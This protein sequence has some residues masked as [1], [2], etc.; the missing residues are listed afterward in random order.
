M[1][2]ATAAQGVYASLD[3]LVRLRHRSRGFSLLPKQPVQSLLAGRHASRLR[4]R[5]L[6]FEEIRKYLP[7][8]DIRQ[9]DWKVTARTRKPHA[10]VYTEER[11]R[12]VILLVDQRLGMFFGSKRNLKSV[13]ACELAAL[14]AW[15]TIDVQDRVG[16][17]VFNDRQVVSIRPHRSQTTVMRILHQVLDMNHA[18]HADST[19]PANPAMLND[20]LHRAQHLAPHDCLIVMITDGDGSDDKTQSLVSQIARHNDI[21]LAFVFDPMEAELPELSQVVLS[22]GERQLEL[23]ASAELQTRYRDDFAEKRKQ[24]KHYLVTREVPVLPISAA[25]PTVD[26]LLRLLGQTGRRQR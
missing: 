10:R 15:R 16:A 1:E 2:S 3:D 17:V 6:N 25:E 22:D 21:I 18:L 12:P 4:G 8:D 11:E 20:A 9:I 13:T 7:G 14:A 24:G 19:V 5:G 23:N 26:Q